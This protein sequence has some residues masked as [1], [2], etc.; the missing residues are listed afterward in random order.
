MKRLYSKNTSGIYIAGFHADIPA[1]AVVISD[2]LYRE[3]F[4]GPAPGKA[5]GHDEAGL[6]C[7]IDSE[8]PGHTGLSV[9]A[10]RDRRINSGFDFE[11]NHYQSRLPSV[12]GAGDWDVFSGKALEAFIAI[13]SGAQ[14][15]DLRWS[16]PA[17]DFS[18]IASDNTRVPMDA[19]TVIALGKAASAHRSAHTFAGSDIKAMTPIPSDF[20]DDKWW[21]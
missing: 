20:A 1:D 21:P 9:D 12:D 15:G 18:W 6:P 2:E 7:L 17:V 11:G 13:S 10:E 14:P 16:D 3:V 8:D 5:L 4:A 19:Q